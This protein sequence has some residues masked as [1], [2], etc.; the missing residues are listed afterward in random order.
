LSRGSVLHPLPV[1]VA[2]IGTLDRGGPQGAPEVSCGT[3]SRCRRA[4]G[5]G[6]ITV[7]PNNPGRTVERHFVVHS[8]LRTL[9]VVTLISAFSGTVILTTQNQGSDTA[10]AHDLGTSGGSLAASADVLAH[11]LPG[12]RS[13]PDA[14]RIEQTPQARAQRL[15]LARSQQESRARLQQALQAKARA[16]AAR[17]AQLA[18]SARL[19]KAAA[20]AREN[21]ARRERLQLKARATRSAGRNPKALARLMLADRGWGAGQFSC[22]DSLWTRESGWNLHAQNPS[23]GAYGIPQALPGR[24][25]SSAG[26]DWRSNAATQIR[27]GL[28]Y[29]ADRY[30][31]PCG[32]WA[33]SEASGWY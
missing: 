9:S 1:R 2:A 5:S 24:K 18:R 6:V 22:L 10:S 15:A 29:I 12:Q 21:A 28:D 16:Q 25:M 33:H 20:V 26:S 31:S 30:G 14:E 11:G 4:Q 3:A 7:A 13:Q 32:A 27:W 8:S 17:A 19:A 23:S